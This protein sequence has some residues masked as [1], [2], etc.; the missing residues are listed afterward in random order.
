MK[1]DKI[2]QIYEFLKENN[3]Y[4]KEFQKHHYCSVSGV[5]DTSDK[6]ILLLHNTA[7]TQSQ[8]KIDE[9]GPFH[10]FI[11]EN[12]ERLSSFYDFMKVISG[13]DTI[14]CSYNN[15]Y[16]SLLEHN[17]WGAKT[18]A[19]FVK[20]IYQMHNGD[21]GD[22][23][24]IWDDC[25]TFD[26]RI[27]RLYLPVDAVIVEIFRQLGHST[28][29]YKSINNVLYGLGY[30]GSEILL[31]DDLWFW[32]FFGQRKIPGAGRVMQWNPNKYWCSPNANKDSDYI[33][34]IKVRSE[35]FIQIL[36][37]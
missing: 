33:D 37:G 24:K 35:E 25:P 15:L 3:K 32:G 23:F 14:E 20:S 13:S 26:N 31:W 2:N 17:G 18:S 22:E 1:I 21:Y 36:Q 34:A 9:L 30:N 10:Q 4:N 16:K 29:N 27:D 19:L 12:K 5:K 7:N 28:P 8:P 6:V 11:F